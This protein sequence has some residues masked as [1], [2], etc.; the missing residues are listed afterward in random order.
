MTIKLPLLLIA[1]IV[2]STF[3]YA[4]RMQKITYNEHLNRAD[5]LLIHEGLLSQHSMR[6]RYKRNGK[7]VATISL[8]EPVLVAMAEREERWGFFQFPCIGRASDG[9]LRI[10]WQMAVDSHKAYGKGSEREIYPYWSYDGG[11]TWKQEKR[12]VSV[13]TRGYNVCMSDGSYLQVYTPESKDIKSFRT[14]P[15][16]LGV[17]DDRSF[18]REDS[19]PEELK[20][21]YF[22]YTDA[23][24]QSEIIHSS[25]N[26]QGLLR[27]SGENL[28]PIVWWGNIKQLANKALVAGVYPAYYINEDRT[29]S[30]G[31]ISFYS[32]H[33]KGKSW[34]IIGK[35]RYPIQGELDVKGDF[36]EPAFEILKDSTFICVMRTGSTS[37]LYR[38]FS[39]DRGK[40]WTTPESF[41]PNGVMPSL[42][43]LKNGILVLTSGRP[44]VQLR[45]SLD[46][47]GR[48]WTEPIDMISFMNTDGSY[49]RDVSCGYVSILETGRNSFIIVYSNFT[50][51]NKAGERR[52]SI[53]CR[54]VVVKRK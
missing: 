26:D 3:S 27:Y 53:W 51:I 17:K 14:F 23:Y 36:S 32:S 35:I 20:G 19:L 28:M 42:M 10:T 11:R 43:L 54:N 49:T 2:N 48:E 21:V 45:F 7:K 38:S 5:S 25:L 6:I 22:A 47:I 39:T 4:Q 50:T 13:R 9:S 41:T 37:P 40:T 15:Q 30:N 24:G 1:I 31:G 18:Y 16:S 12:R 33:D 44:G 8:S 34:D 52:K 29:L 46:G